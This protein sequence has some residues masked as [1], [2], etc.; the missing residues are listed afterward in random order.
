MNNDL[1]YFSIIGFVFIIIL[2]LYLSESSPLKIDEKEE[3]INEMFQNPQM[4]TTRSQTKGASKY[5]KWGLPEEPIKI[6]KCKTKNDDIPP[7]YPKPIK[8]DECIEEKECSP[9]KNHNCSDCDILSNK[10]IHKYVL[11]SSI[12]PC[13]DTSK[14]ATKN[15]IESCPD[16]SKYILKSEIPNCDKFDKSEYILKSEIPAC[17]K[18][19]I[20]PVCPV[21][22]VCPP[23]PPQ[24]TIN[25]FKITD[26]KDL[27]N[28]IHKDDI[29][30]YI[31]NSNFCGKYKEEISKLK[32]KCNSIP[33]STS[34]PMPVYEEESRNS[35]DDI[36]D[37]TKDLKKSKSKGLYAGDSLFQAI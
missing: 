10:D 33:D 22:P 32:K 28:Y 27:K 11:K 35:I 25:Q 1:I 36:F 23:L 26:H 21:C 3:I 6:K 14:F 37:S 2:G 9:K 18:C 5:Y 20:C 4:S 7:F 13:P 31:E 29:K 34:K 16:I 19:P 24:K 12:P 30:N 17:P 8:Y 15:M